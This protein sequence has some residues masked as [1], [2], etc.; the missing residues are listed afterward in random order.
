ME[1]LVTTNEHPKKTYNDGIGPCAQNIHNT[2][3]SIMNTFKKAYTATLR[4]NI[5]F[6]L[7]SYNLCIL[8]PTLQ[9]GKITCVICNCNLH[10]I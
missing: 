10:E 6:T 7:T 3:G 2:P 1:N 8:T 9:L 4:T 5:I